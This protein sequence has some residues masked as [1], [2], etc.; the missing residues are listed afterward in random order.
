MTSSL[1]KPKTKPSAWSISTISTLS[2]NSSESLVVSSKPPNPAPNT[3]TR[4]CVV[5]ALSDDVAHRPYEKD[6]VTGNPHVPAPS[7]RVAHGDAAA[8]HGPGPP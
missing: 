8:R 1:E 3:K 7:E 5:S 4:I 6:A 2:P